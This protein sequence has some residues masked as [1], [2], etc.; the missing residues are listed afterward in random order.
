MKTGK[1]P[2]LYMALIVVGS[3]SILATF[4]HGGDD[5]HGYPEA[6]KVLD[7]LSSA[8]DLLQAAHHDFGGHKAEIV[9]DIDHAIH[10]LEAAQNEH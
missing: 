2:L 4:G 7:H 9:K 10:E 8:K 5:D 6:H 1:F 3:M